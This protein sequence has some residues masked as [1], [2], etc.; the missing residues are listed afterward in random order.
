MATLLVAATFLAGCGGSSG[1]PP[2]NAHVRFAHAAGTKIAYYERGHGPPLAMLM[3]TAST[4][5]EWDPALLRLLARDHRLILFD[6]P[7][8]GLSGPWRG[9][10]FDSLADATAALMGAIH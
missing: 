3:G 7:G 5:S 4:M 1:D 9:R 6:Y 10:G 2:F 8:I